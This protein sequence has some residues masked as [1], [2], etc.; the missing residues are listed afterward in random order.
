MTPKVN[1]MIF[2]DMCLKK[3]LLDEEDEP[4]LTIIFVFSF[5]KNNH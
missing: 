3:E 2:F 4:S 1:V 5:P